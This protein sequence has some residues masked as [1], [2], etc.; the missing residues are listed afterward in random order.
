MKIVYLH[1]YFKL[2]IERGGTRSYDLAKQFVKAGHSV[3]VITTTSDKSVAT[4]NSWT[5]IEHDGI[6]VHY[7]YTPYG[8]GMS[9]PKR[10]WAFFKFMLFST[11]RLLMVK[12]DVVLATSTPLTIGIPALLKKWLAKTPYIFEVRDVWP[13]AVIAVGAIKNKFFQKTLLW[14]ER[15][16]YRN[17]ASIVPLSTDMRKSIIERFPEACPKIHHVIPNIAELNRFK[18]SVI[19]VNLRE[20][21]GF[22]PGFTVLYAGTF[23]RVNGLH[24][25]VELAAMTQKLDATLCYILL[26]EGI[27]KQEIIEQAKSLGILNENL[28]VFDSISKDELPAWYAS[29]SMGSSFVIEIKEL[30]ANSA[31]KFFDTLAAGKPVLIN[32]EGWQAKTIRNKEVGYVLPSEITEVTAKKF[33]TYTKNKPLHKQQCQNALELA[34]SEYSLEVASQRYLEIFGKLK[35]DGKCHNTQYE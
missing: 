33:V 32:H 35:P 4:A 26:G 19:P 6:D 3:S 29:V 27:L 17:A 7:I 11:I 34:E 31:N 5:V 10:I 2:P 8:N 15:T 25:V 23:G 28:Y 1:Q 9:Y 13:E 14:L 22:Q 21:L 30:W 18:K 12:C 20:K 16:I 24:K